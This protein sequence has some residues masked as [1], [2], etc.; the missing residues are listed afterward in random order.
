[1]IHCKRVE[2]ITNSLE[3][4]AL[5]HLLKEAGVGSF[6]IFP[7]VSGFGRRGDQAA[8]EITGA[9]QNSCILIACTPEESEKIIAL[10]RPQLTR[11]GGICLVSDAQY[12]KH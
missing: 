11:Q 6:S 7:N 9:F 5:C 10:V 1:M 2:I 4:K 3:A 12:I 8:D